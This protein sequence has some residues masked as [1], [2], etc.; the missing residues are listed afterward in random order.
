MGDVPEYVRVVV[1]DTAYEMSSN[2]KS[3]RRRTHSRVCIT[4]VKLDGLSW[5]PHDHYF[6]ASDGKSITKT[7]QEHGPFVEGDDP[8]WNYPPELYD[9]QVEPWDGTPKDEFVFRVLYQ[10]EE[11]RP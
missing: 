10:D 9:A 6:V 4:K 11:G 3:K 5:G 7:R 2:T 8:D 1:D